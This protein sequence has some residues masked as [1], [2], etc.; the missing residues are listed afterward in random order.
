MYLGDSGGSDVDIYPL[1]GPNQ[2]QIGSITSGIVYPWGLSLAADGSVYVADA[3]NGTV[4]VYPYG[5]SSPSMTYS[6][7][8]H[9]PLYALADSAGHV[10]VGDREPAAHN[11]GF[12]VEYGAGA[13]FPIKKVR[14][15]SEEDGMAFDA[16]GNLYVAYRKTAYNSSIAKFGPG[17]TNKRLLGMTI[18]Q[19]QGLVVDSSGNIVVVE[20]ASDDIKVF[21]P[22]TTT[23]S[24]TLNLSTA[25]RRS[26]AQLAMQNSETTLWVSTEGGEV[27]SMPYPLTAST[28]AAEYEQ[29]KVFSNGIAVTH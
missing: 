10:Y 2:K 4:T 5:S 12:I 21:P 25:Y 11:K 29:G 19:P 23:P 28:K 16:N 20:S 9:Q 15:G 13:N 3:S 17:L 8:L 7:G 22:G 6:K 27:L 24:V 14:L 18:N 1:T 26:L